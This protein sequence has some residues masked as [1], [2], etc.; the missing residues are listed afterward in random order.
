MRM[1]WCGTC[2]E[3]RAMHMGDIL[4]KR[5]EDRFETLEDVAFRAGNDASN[6]SRI[7]RGLQ[8]PSVA[9]LEALAAAMDVR[10]SDLYREL[11][12]GLASEPR[13]VLRGVAEPIQ[14]WNADLTRLQRHFR[15]LDAE[16]RSMLIDVAR[17]LCKY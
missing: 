9:L 17:L 8:Q 6:L 15:A 12:G 4:K 3:N 5:R 1:A 16:Q 10:V 14:P 13:R 7:E 2:S 11:E